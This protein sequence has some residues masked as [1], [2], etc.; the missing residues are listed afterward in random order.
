LAAAGA[1][2]TAAS[3]RLAPNNMVHTSTNS[4]FIGSPLKEK[5]FR[6]A[7]ANP[8]GEKKLRNENNF[9]AGEDSFAHR[10]F[11]RSGGTERRLASEG[12]AGRKET[13]AFSTSPASRGC[14]EMTELAFG[15]WA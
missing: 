7:T 15:F 13:Q 1:G 8:G 14:L 12:L 6:V 4:F 9:A 2:L 11:R 5:N 3:E 10:I